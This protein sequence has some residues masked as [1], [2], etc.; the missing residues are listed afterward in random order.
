M[1]LMTQAK[2]SICKKKEAASVN[3]QVQVPTCAVDTP[4]WMQM[5]LVS[6]KGRM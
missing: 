5:D 3:P 2:V 1:S 4:K 6:L